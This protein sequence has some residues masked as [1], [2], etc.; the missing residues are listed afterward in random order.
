MLIAQLIGFPPAG[1]DHDVSV[2][3]RSRVTANAG[4][5]ASVAID[6][7]PAATGSRRRVGLPDPRT[8]RCHLRHFALVVERTALRYVLRRW[9]L[10]GIPLP[11][12]LAREA[13]HANPSNTANSFDV[14]V[15]HPRL[16][17]HRALSGLLSRQ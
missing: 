16:P 10:F 13:T 3:R 8:L 12:S 1:S 7:E 5:A 11:L 14:H 4:F 15:R 9:T 17:A 6:L 2:T